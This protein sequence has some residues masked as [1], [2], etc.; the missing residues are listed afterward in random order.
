MQLICNKGDLIN[1]IETLESYKIGTKEYEFYVNLVKKGV[2]FVA[3]R[4]QG[5]TKFYP[6]RFMG[7]KNNT[8]D[9]HISNEYKDGKETNPTISKILASKPQGNKELETQYRNYC[10]TLG[11]IANEKGAF[12]VYRKYWVLTND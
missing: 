8:Y 10:E 2:C 12:G 5:V 7:Y 11:F 1:N 3:Y 9:E 4:H 6:S